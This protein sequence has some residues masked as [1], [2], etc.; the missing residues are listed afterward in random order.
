MAGSIK[1]MIYT[2]DQGQRYATKI[3]ESN[4]NLFGFEDVADIG[5][6]A[7]TVMPKGFKMRK[8]N[9]LSAEGNA[10]RSIPCGNSTNA[11][12]TG[13]DTNVTLNGLV[14]GVTSTTGE[15]A[16]R[17]YAIDTGLNDGSAG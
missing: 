13:A 14:Y 10:R 2:T 6:A 5:D 8:V 7:Y 9:L 17:V 16:V 11:F 15:K 1:W 3:D 4:G 12:Y